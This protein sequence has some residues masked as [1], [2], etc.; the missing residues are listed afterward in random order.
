MSLQLIAKQ[1]EAKGRNG[2]SV[3]VHMT[4]GEV[5]GLQKLAENAGGSLSVN[6]E[7]GLVEANFLKQMLPTLVGA[8]VGF[9]TMN[10]MLGA[11]AGAAVGGF[12]ARRSDQDVLTGMLMGGMGG[13][14]GATIGSG[15]SAAG[16]PA[17][18]GA[19]VAKNT[20]ANIPLQQAA[21]AQAQAVQ[22]QQAQA[23]QQAAMAEGANLSG[24]EAAMLNTR[25]LPVAVAPTVA[26]AAAQTTSVIPGP[27][28]PVTPPARTFADLTTR[29]RMDQGLRGLK[30]LGTTE[31]RDVA[32][33]NIG[34]SEGLI[35]A[36]TFGAMPYLNAAPT[37]SAPQGIHP[38][39]SS[40]I[41]RSIPNQSVEAYKGRMPRY[42]GGKNNVY[43]AVPT[44]RAAQGGITSLAAG[45]AFEDIQAYEGVM[46]NY[47]Y[48]NGNFLRA[49]TQPR[50][51]MR[52]QGL[53]AGL[54]SPEVSQPRVI[55]PV[56]QRPVTFADMGGSGD[57]YT[58]NA[59][60]VTPEQQRAYY[61]ENPMM[62]NVTGIAQNLVGMTPIGAMQ[63]YFDP[64]G[65]AAQRAMVQQAPAPVD[66]RAVAIDSPLGMG[67]RSTEFG[68]PSGISLGT[69]GA[70]LA[71]AQKSA[72][73]ERQQDAAMRDAV[74]AT[75]AQ[76]TISGGAD[77]DAPVGDDKGKDTSGYSA[78]DMG[79]AQGG[80][81]G[82]AKGGLKEGGFVVPADVVAFLGGGNSDNGAEKIER[83]FPNAM[84]IDGPDGGQ[85]DTVKTSI[86]GKQPARVAH[87]E[88][89]I[90]PQDVKRAGG[91]KVLYAMLDRV[92]VAATGSKKQIKPVS[93]ERAMA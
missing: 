85:E 15:I 49:A 30:A 33:K 86:E 31:G 9:M 48:V 45:G 73:Y 19:D 50:I 3:L 7:T 16:A 4:H 54:L 39:L 12:Q 34:G 67:L 55:A 78:A 65:V 53:L 42:T 38:L 17:T 18:V 56:A 82:L 21:Q 71:A 26:P 6:P 43:A 8:G 24:A 44:F 29:E 2:D 90:P 92:R 83:M 37:E 11:A 68:A 57:G 93:L 23:M 41:D 47:S 22:A 75:L 36:A 81:L 80:L 58:P 35:R 46:P 25:R 28:A 51:P 63:N 10:P 52:P 1:M 77:Y 76:G 87:G 13:Y 27:T 59:D 74:N 66:D 89:Y 14:G 91:A 72:E 79:L 40:R 32:Y 64:E 69:P 62:A 61:A 88:V 70:S 20:A 60:F 84:Y 5:A